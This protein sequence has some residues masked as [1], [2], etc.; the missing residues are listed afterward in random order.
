MSE[1]SVYTD[2]SSSVR[3][4]AKALVTVGDRILLVKERHDDGT[5]FW[6]LPGGGVEPGESDIEALERELAE[7]LRCRAEVLARETSL[8]YAH[9]SSERLSRYV[10][11]RCRLAS[12]PVPNP[13]EGILNCRLARPGKAPPSTLPQVRHLWRTLDCF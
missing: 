4:G 7:E 3:R 1:Q 13:L 6:T 10:V 2:V 11:Y 9:S 12:R 5:P 8:L